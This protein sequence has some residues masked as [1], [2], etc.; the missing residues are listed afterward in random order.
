MR[1]S[2]VSVSIPTLN[3]QIYIER[4]LRA[5]NSQSYKNIEI[6][7]VDGG[8]KDNTISIAKS[9][10]IE[11]IITCKD[12]LLKSRYEGLKQ[13]HGEYIL[14]L[15]SDQI[16]EHTAIERAVK[17]IEKYE[18]DMLV[19]E[20]DV[21]K[22]TNWLEK[23]FQLDRKLIHTIR[24]FDPYTGV[25][26]PR[27]YRSS[28]LNKA[29]KNIPKNALDNV[30]GQDHAIIYFEVWQYSNKVDLLLEAVKHIEPNSIRVVIK[31][32]YRWGYTSKAAH[33]PRYMELLAKKERFRKGLFSK[34]TYK[35]SVA[36]ITLLILKGLPYSLGKLRAKV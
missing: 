9:L 29:F 25:M 22:A 36:S 24:D 5:I 27:F 8:S 10:G 26:L 31:K 30:G 14:L 34:G 3:S 12:S 7:I 17:Q 32:F 16:L 18:L 13:A 21:Y 4:C 28:L 1:E 2:L 23:L 15:D 20:E 19:F 33:E 35:A 11:K 6:N